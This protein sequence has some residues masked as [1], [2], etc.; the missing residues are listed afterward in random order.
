MVAGALLCVSGGL[1]VL[2]GLLL[3][4]VATLGLVGSLLGLLY[5]A[6]GG[7]GVVVGLQVQQLVAGARTAAIEV[8]AAGIVASSLFAFRGGVTAA[9]GVLL[10]AVAIYLLFRVESRAAF[11]STRR[12]FGRR[13]R[14]RGSGRLGRRP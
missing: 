11:P 3:F 9:L 14:D 1:T 10:P 7:L 2:N 6:T 5:L 4:A 13:E 12:P 8:G